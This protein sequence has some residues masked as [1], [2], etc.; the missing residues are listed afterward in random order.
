M[1]NVCWAEANLHFANGISKMAFTIYSP[2]QLMCCSSCFARSI[3]LQI[4]FHLDGAILERTVLPDLIQATIQFLCIKIW[5]RFLWNLVEIFWFIKEEKKKKCLKAIIK[6]FYTCH[7]HINISIIRFKTCCIGFVEGGEIQESQKC[8]FNDKQSPA[9]PYSSYG[10]QQ[11]TPLTPTSE[12]PLLFLLLQ[13]P[14]I[15]TLNMVQLAFCF[16]N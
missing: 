4:S 8:Y 1:H 15:Y 16:H 12:I 5:E 3:W 10:L 14:V 6:I 13:T 11:K 2:H 7:F 9:E